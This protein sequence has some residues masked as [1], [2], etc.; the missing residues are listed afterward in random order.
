MGTENTDIVEM[1]VEIPFWL[2]VAAQKNN[3]D[4]SAL[5]IE[6]LKRELGITQL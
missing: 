3:V 2:D 5:M 4:M 1:K 6:A